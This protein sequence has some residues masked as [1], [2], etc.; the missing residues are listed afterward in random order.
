[1]AIID[2]SQYYSDN[3]SQ[4]DFMDAQLIDKQ[5]NQ[6][7]SGINPT[8]GDPEILQPIRTTQ[9]EPILRGINDSA[10][11]QDLSSNFERTMNDHSI[12]NDFQTTKAPTQSIGSK[13]AGNAGGIASFGTNAYQQMSQVAQSDKEADMRTASLAVQGMSL[14]ASIGGIYGAAAGLIIGGGIGMLK[15]VPDR[16]KR[17]RRDYENYEGKLFD[18]IN[19]RKTTADD[20]QRIQEL[21]NQLN[22]KKAQ[23]GLI[24]LNY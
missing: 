20:Y 3:Q 24:N 11:K 18:E 15:K 17:L 7:F 19:Q 6:F 9:A 10:L 14:G 22:L 16:K 1:M 23:M 21:E 4:T 2:L 12:E 8:T 13:V 5:K